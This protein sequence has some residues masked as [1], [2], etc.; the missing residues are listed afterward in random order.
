MLKYDE[1]IG[2][3]ISKRNLFYVGIFI[4][5]LALLIYIFFESVLIPYE[6]LITGYI[7][8]VLFFWLQ[9]IIFSSFKVLS[10]KEFLIRITIISVGVKSI[11][12]I[13]LYY[14]FLYKTKSPFEFN[15]VDSIAYHR[16]GI[17]LSKFFEN[18]KYDIS[19][20][21][22]ESAFS[23]RGFNILIGWIYVL[24][25]QSIVFTRLFFSFISAVSVLLL[26]KIS[27]Q[28]FDEIYARYISILFLLMPNFN[29]YL[30]THLKE[31][32][33]IFIVLLFLHQTIRFIE[34]ERKYKRN[35]ICLLF[36]ILTLFL[37]R[38]ALG[39]AAVLATI[40]YFFTANSISKKFNKLIILSIVFITAVILIIN[41]AIGVEIQNYLGKTSTAVQENMQFRA[42][43]FDGNKFA[44]YA[45]APLFISIILIVPFPSFVLIKGQEFIW[46]FIAGNLI[47]NIIA[48]FLFVG[49]FSLNKT[50]F[51][52]TSLLIYFSIIYL[53]ILANSGFAISERF[54]LPIL[55]IFLL[56]SGFGIIANEKRNIS[57][58]F[59]LYLFII[60][61]IILVWNYIKV[62]GR[63]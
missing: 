37:F 7:E 62:I 63:L 49:I 58:Y 60:L 43:R 25:K 14:Y 5:I 30:G 45:G 47:K 18:G 17:Y 55:P 57:K 28:L 59:P 36:C 39:G 51:R 31:T 2:K 22:K 15:A 23:D 1:E 21:L 24:T 12:A 50:L 35:L 56:F 4:N 61:I 53:L 40:A 34:K 11:A 38:T 52:K 10:K 48:F 44:V 9:Q 29:L 16:N 27:D 26:Y 33:L 54:H 20:L 32:F 13:I 46:M 6:F 3:S 8:V 42:E 19:S 41:S